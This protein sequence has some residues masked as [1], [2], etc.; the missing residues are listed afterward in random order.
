MNGPVLLSL[1]HC[2]PY[3]TTKNGG[4]PKRAAFW[5]FIRDFVVFWF[6]EIGTP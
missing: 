6:G 4:Q 1:T 5:R 2:S 3:Y